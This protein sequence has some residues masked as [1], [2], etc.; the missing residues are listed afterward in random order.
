MAICSSETYKGGMQVCEHTTGPMHITGI[1][2]TGVT[3]QEE[4]CD[5]FIGQLTLP[6]SRHFESKA[7]WDGPKIVAPQ[8]PDLLL[9]EKV[10]YSRQHQA[11]PEDVWGRMGG[12]GGRTHLRHRPHDCGPVTAADG[13]NVSAAESSLVRLRQSQ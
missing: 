5:L 2:D 1:E 10:S 12:P 9:S 7:D 11:L 4:G 6:V 13:G 3:P 8:T